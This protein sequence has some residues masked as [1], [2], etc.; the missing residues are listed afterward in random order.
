M[1]ETEKGQTR[2]TLEDK[3]QHNSH[4]WEREAFGGN[5]ASTDGQTG[6]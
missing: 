5:A 3:Y 1:G 6:S 4:S 2:E